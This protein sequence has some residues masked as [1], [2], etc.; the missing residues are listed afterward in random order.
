MTGTEVRS[1]LESI[2]RAWELA[3]P[4]KARVARGILFKLL[5]SMTL[6]ASFA[7]VVWAVTGLYSGRELTTVW[8]LQITGFMACSLAGQLLFGWLSARD[9]WLASYQVAGHLRLQMLDH[10]R[11]LPLGF[12]QARH[13]GDTVTV[14]TSDMQMLE[15]FFC[16]RPAPNC[17][18]F[19]TAP[20]CLHRALA[21]GLADRSGG[22][23]IDHPCVARF[24]RNVPASVAAR[25]Q[26]SGHSG[27]SRGTD[28]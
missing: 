10:L 4:Q 22:C 18:G 1:D 25:A 6:G 15:A 17:P 12:H 14:L 24:C 5:Q 8:I 27:R 7:L 20:R 26:A 11:R 19:G 3:G 2:A 16:R 21:A 28:D 9:S 23:S 13:R